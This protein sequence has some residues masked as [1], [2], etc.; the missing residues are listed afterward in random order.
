MELFVL[1][2]AMPS[3]PRLYSI[4]CMAVYELERI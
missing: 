4:E 3:V 1:D 2:F